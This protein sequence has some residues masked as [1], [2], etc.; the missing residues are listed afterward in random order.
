MH[1]TFESLQQRFNY[2]P[3][4]APKASRHQLVRKVCLEA[5][6]ELVDVTGAPTRE[7]S[8]AITKLEEA[9]FWANAAIAREADVGAEL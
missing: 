3:P 4:N 7:Q 6:E 1:L 9:M 5:A 2:H 8:L